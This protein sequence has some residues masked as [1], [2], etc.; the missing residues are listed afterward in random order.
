[1]PADPTP[2]PTP[3]DDQPAAKP[4]I[5]GNIRAA[6]D[7]KPTTSMTLGE[8]LDELR[9]RL[10]M[11]LFGL[12]PLV[13]IAFYFGD[14]LLQYILEPARQALAE[15]D[16][17]DMVAIGPLETF[18]AY[19]RVSFITAI[20]VGAPW[21]FYQAW[22]FVAPGLHKHEKRF[23]Y[24]LIPL[25]GILTASG[26]AFLF[27]VVLPLVLTFL[28]AFGTGVGQ[29]PIETRPLPQGITLPSLPILDVDPDAPTPGEVWINKKLHRVRLCIAERE[30]KPQVLSID[31]YSEGGIRQQYRVSEVLSL[32][33]T[34]IAAFAGAFQAPLIVLLL[35]WA[36]VIDRVFLAKYRRHAAFACVVLAA[37]VMPGDPASMIAM[38]VP[39]IL[40]YELGGI[41]LW[42]FPA[43]RIA[44][45]K[46]TT[47]AED[48][49]P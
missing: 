19:M 48:D 11:A 49:R 43:R 1:M 27:K 22:R 44:G 10:I 35:G 3:P 37:A 38:A 26:V 29:R 16:Q 23:V 41:L 14:H 25:S 5:A 8:H 17:P 42:L 21:I 2:P 15:S 34:L 13:I 30:G 45:K 20:V 6:I 9:K 36:G 12:L 4:T 39:L 46:P 33:L 28:I 47:E 7:G 24:F 18:S 31:L 40:L 32:M